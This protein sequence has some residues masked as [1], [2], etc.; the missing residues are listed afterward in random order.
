MDPRYPVVFGACLT[1]FTIVG[2]MFSFGLFFDVFEEEFG[3]S[4]TI[5]S[6]STSLAFLVMGCSRTSSGA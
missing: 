5:L 1:Q 2:L 3:W 6:G 4:R